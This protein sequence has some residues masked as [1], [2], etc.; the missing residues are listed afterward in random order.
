M[1]ISETMVE[2]KDIVLR[3]ANAKILKW[4]GDLYCLSFLGLFI[5]GALIPFKDIFNI[6]YWLGVFV[7]VP[8]ALFTFIVTLTVVLIEEHRAQEAIDEHKAH[9]RKATLNKSP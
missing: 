2:K 1:S 9:D 6:Y 7:L 8:A 5:C 3:W 4:Y